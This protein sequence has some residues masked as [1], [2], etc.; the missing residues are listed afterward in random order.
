MRICIRLL[1]ILLLASCDSIKFR[2]KNGLCISEHSGDI[3]YQVYDESPDPRK[4]IVNARNLSNGKKV[5][6][7]YLMTRFKKVNCP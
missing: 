1:F 6:L 3:I 2:P 4:T 5:E 7:N